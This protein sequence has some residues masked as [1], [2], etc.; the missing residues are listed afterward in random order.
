[1]NFYNKVGNALR[2]IDKNKISFKSA[3]YNHTSYEGDR[4]F[5]KVYKLVVEVLKCKKILNEIIEI[6]FQTLNYL[7]FPLG[8]LCH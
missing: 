4:N 7:C 3:I 8:Y 1:M 5:K 2:D 6:F